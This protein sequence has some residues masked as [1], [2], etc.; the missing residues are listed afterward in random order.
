MGVRATVRNGRLTVDEP[1]DLPDGTV[2]DLVIDDEGDDLDERDRQALNAAISRSLRDSAEGRTAPADEVLRKLRERRGAKAGP[3][4][5]R[6][7]AA[8]PRA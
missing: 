8:H 1:V 7:R 2:L 5:S 3:D 4:D 6:G